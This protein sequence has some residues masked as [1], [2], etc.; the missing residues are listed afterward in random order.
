MSDSECEFTINFKKFE[1]SPD[2]E[3]TNEVVKE[4]QLDE[5]GQEGK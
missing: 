3:I 2:V 4:T 1:S 5:A